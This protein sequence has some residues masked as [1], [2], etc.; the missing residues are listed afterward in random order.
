MNEQKTLDSNEQLPSPILKFKH[1]IILLVIGWIFVSIGSLFKI[2]SLPY[3]S[4]IL[5]I[6][7]LTYGL[8]LLLLVI[9][10]LLFK[11][12]NSILNK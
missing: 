6:G 8:A 2:E 11:D 3:A 7:F 10:L 12:K 4:L 9:K 1:P 5:T